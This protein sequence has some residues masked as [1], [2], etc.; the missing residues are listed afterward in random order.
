MPEAVRLSYIN[1]YRY[2]VAHTHTH[3]HTHV[4]YSPMNYMYTVQYVCL[5]VCLLLPEAVSLSLLIFSPSVS[6]L[7]LAC[8]FPMVGVRWLSRRHCFTVRHPY[9]SCPAIANECFRARKGFWNTCDLTYCS[10]LI[11]VLSF[12]TCDCRHSSRIWA[13]QC[14]AQAPHTR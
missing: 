10:D 12:N 4:R 7:W 2:R 8:T 9:P 14:S 5:F 1:V 6:V 3:T 13:C 11:A